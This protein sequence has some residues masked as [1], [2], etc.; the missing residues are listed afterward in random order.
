MN[1]GLPTEAYPPERFEAVAHWLLDRPE[2][3]ST[4]R[5]DLTRALRERGASYTGGLTGVADQMVLVASELAANAIL[6]ALPP[7]RV[8]L[9]VSD[10]EFVLDVVDHAPELPPEIAENREIGQGGAGLKIA[11]RIALDIAWYPDGAAKHVW[12]RFPRA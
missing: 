5:E 4:F 3:L 7:T 9:L 8:L 1:P 10:N 11:K 2:H 12:A 6:H